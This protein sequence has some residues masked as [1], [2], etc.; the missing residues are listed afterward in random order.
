[1]VEK[2]ADRSEGFN[3][4]VTEVLTNDGG[5]RHEH[6]ENHENQEDNKEAFADFE[7]IFR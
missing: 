4:V 5:P 3:A 6:I 1:M 7:G 2:F